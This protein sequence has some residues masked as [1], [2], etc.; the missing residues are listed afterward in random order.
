MQ[1]CWEMWSL[2]GPLFAY[3][4]SALRKDSMNL[5]GQMA[6]PSQWLLLLEHHSVP[7]TT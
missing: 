1:R 3:H 2:A 5:G 7:G 6:A 4:E